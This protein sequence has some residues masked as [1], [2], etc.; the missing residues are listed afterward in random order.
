[1]RHA[2]TAAMK[3]SQKSVLIVDD[4]EDERTIQ[5]T[6][7]EH[8]GY[9]VREAGDGETALAL[10]R[11]E[12]PDLVLLDIAMPRVDGLTVCRS[13]REAPDT[14]AVAVLF[15]TASTTADVEDRVNRAGADGILIKPVDPNE[16][17]GEV[18]RLIG[19][20]GG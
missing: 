5:R 15:L 16:V 19:R 17:A 9:T 7:L 1:M 12:P 3:I 10:A 6:L 14:R 2:G 13:L 8:L 20:P 4:Q 18:A 11:E